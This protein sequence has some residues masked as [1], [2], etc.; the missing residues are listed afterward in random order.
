[1]VPIWGRKE[2]ENKNFND[3]TKNTNGANLRKKINH[4]PPGDDPSAVS[5]E[6]DDDVGELEISLLLQMGQDTRTEEDLALPQAVQ[7]GVQI[8]GFDLHFGVG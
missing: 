4:W 6:A 5:L 7:G 8:Q 2:V 3:S 1:M